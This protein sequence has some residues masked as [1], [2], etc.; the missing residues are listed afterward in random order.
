MK[1]NIR[2]ENVATFFVISVLILQS[3]ISLKLGGLPVIT[4]PRIMLVVCYMWVF[5]VK[6]RQAAFWRTARQCAY[7]VPLLLFS[8]VCVYT[9]VLVPDFNTF[10]S[11]FVDNFLM[12]YLFLYVMK[13]C[14]SLNKII[15]IVTIC[16]YVVTIFGVVEFL[17]SIN[18]FTQFSLS[19][20]DV[21]DVSYR[22]DSLRIRGPYGH[23]L[24][25]GMVMLLLFPITC[26]R[27]NDNC[28]DLFKNKCL[29]ILIALSMFFTG[30][31]S[32]IG[33]FLIELVVLYLLTGKKY[34]TPQLL[35]TV[36]IVIACSG[37][38][39]FLGNTEFVQYLFRQFFY[40]IDQWFG[41]NHSLQYGG[42]ASIKA[43][44]IARDRIWKIP[45][46]D[47][48]NL[49]LGKGVS[50]HDVFVIDGWKV[51]SIDCYYVR[52]YVAYGIGGIIALLLVVAT[53][54]R[55]SISG[56]VHLKNMGIV[57][58][59]I[60]GIAYLANLLYV[61]ELST[62]R[63]FLM[64]VAFSEALRAKVPLLSVAGSTEPVKNS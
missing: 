3:L 10:F 55:R 24:A 7:N 56:Y 35:Y 32:G 13:N 21:I 23:A 15:S 57:A 8:A 46:S 58:A 4:L 26:Y 6:E 44:S 9:A 19:N 22:D 52:V 31:R 43:S 48:V 38:V 45:F 62:F 63:L 40:I 33:L 11:F 14:L 17:T 25:Y 64:L 5:L 37:I 51:V 12:F 16:L 53:F 18:V 47:N 36:I 61:D 2:F 41:T 39:Y 30:A 34:R 49:W 27:E 42:D 54:M 28:I 20:T 1:V 29:L 60:A 50:N 59:A